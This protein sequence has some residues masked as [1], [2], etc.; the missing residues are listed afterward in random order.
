MSDWLASGI[1]GLSRNAHGSG[2]EGPAEAQ[3]STSNDQP[4]SSQEPEKPQDDD[5]SRYELAILS[6]IS[7]FHIGHKTCDSK[8]Y[9]SV[10][11]K[12]HT[13]GLLQ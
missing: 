1:S 3:A 9:S 2:A 4:E 8:Y 5:A 10:E 11:K 7:V 6:N 13:T 12:F